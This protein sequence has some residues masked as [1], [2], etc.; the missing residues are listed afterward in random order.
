MASSS[1]KRQERKKKMVNFLGGKCVDCSAADDLEF[2]HQ[3]PSLK[4]FKISDAL[5]WSEEKLL[6]E[7][8]KCVLRCK[9]CHHKKT[10]E[11]DEY[12]E[13]SGHGTLWRVKKYKCRCEDCLAYLNRY[14]SFRQALYRLQKLK[15]DS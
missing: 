3:E 6:E 5:D 2:D 1:E 15:A 11:N 9:P 10:L 4:N 12:G 8:K 13:R 14:N 7:V